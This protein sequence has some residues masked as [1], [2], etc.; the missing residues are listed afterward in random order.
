LSVLLWFTTSAYLIPIF[1]IVLKNSIMVCVF[2]LKYWRKIV[3]II[4]DMHSES[5][6]K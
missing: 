3:N 6:M 4:E 2:V 5:V 1:N